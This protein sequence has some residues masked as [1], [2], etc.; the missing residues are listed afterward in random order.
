MPSP[1]TGD[2]SDVGN[3]IKVLVQEGLPANISY[4]GW[5][6]LHTASIIGDADLVEWLLNECGC[7][8]YHIMNPKR[9]T[10]LDVAIWCHNPHI[11]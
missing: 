2:V 4:D 10:A 5:S 6:F 11:V 1:I 3:R 8:K 7:H 9:P